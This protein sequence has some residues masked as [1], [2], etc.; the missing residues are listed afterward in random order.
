M[1]PNLMVGKIMTTHHRVLAALPFF[2]FLALLASGAD[3]AAQED[4]APVAPPLAAEFAPDGRVFCNGVRRQDE[5]LVVNTRTIGCNCDPESLRSGLQFENYAVTD[6][7]GHRHWQSTDLESFL[8]LGS[9]LPTIIFIHGN[10]ISPSDTRPWR[11]R[12]AWR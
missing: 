6:E 2:L 7:V 8:A 5:I 4:S 10:Q 11:W 1:L 3:A 9:S 12:P